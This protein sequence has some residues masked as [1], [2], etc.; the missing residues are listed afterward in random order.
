MTRKIEAKEQSVYRRLIDGAL[1]M[2]KHEPRKPEPVKFRE[3]LREVLTTPRSVRRVAVDA[4]NIVT[5]GVRATGS[6]IIA[7]EIPV[8]QLH[9]EM[10][11]HINRFTSQA[12]MTGGLPMSVHV[13][14]R[15]KCVLDFFGGRCITI[16]VELDSKPE[17]SLANFIVEESAVDHEEINF[18]LVE[19]INERKEPKITDAV[20]W[21]NIE[22][23]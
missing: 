16:R 19:N 3:K 14:D 5:D 12:I 8:D 20:I 7:R 13:V 11:I 23:F 2:P 1:A 10:T 22:K 15:F 9:R 6:T 4:Y 18:D 17:Q 21:Q